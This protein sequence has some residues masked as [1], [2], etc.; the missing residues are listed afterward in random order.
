MCVR[1]SQTGSSSKSISSAL[2]VV[3]FAVSFNSVAASAQTFDPEKASPMS[4]LVAPKDGIA[5]YDLR[6]RAARLALENAVEAEP[7]LEQ[8]VR[9]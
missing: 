1:I 5:Y 9:D 8:L 2:F 7:L 6:N 4:L 3:A